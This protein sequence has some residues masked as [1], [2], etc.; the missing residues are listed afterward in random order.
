M[1]TTKKHA[2]KLIFFNEK[3]IDED[4]DNFWHRKLTL[5][6]R[7]CHFSIAWFR[8]EVDLTKKFVLWKSAIFHSI[9]LPFDEQ[10]AEKILNVIYCWGQQMLLFWKLVDE[11]QMG[12]SRH[13]EARDILSKLSIFLPLRAILKNPYH[14]ETPCIIAVESIFS[15]CFSEE[16]RIPKSTFEINWP[17]VHTY[18]KYC[19]N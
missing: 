13:N 8:A 12:N 15:V 18:N 14:Y 7:N 5:K 11:T 6:V 16:L 2:P 17:L 10:F 4:S 9:I 1:S 3:K 19:T